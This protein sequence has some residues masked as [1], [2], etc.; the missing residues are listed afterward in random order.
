MGREEMPQIST[1]V[2]SFSPCL[3]IGLQNPW[4]CVASTAAWRR[5][6]RVP[7]H[8]GA[9]NSDTQLVPDTLVPVCVAVPCSLTPYLESTLSSS[10]QKLLTIYYKRAMDARAAGN[11]APRGS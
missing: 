3:T 7:T 10:Q 8:I 9:W 6:P 4:A 5:V 11:A 1:C 2:L